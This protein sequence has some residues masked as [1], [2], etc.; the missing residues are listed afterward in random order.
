MTLELVLEVDDYIGSHMVEGLE[1]EGYWVRGVYLKGN[2]FRVSAAGE[3]S[4][5]DLGDTQFISHVHINSESS[6]EISEIHQFAADMVGAGLDFTCECDADFMHNSGILNL[7][8]S[9]ERKGK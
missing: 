1:S 6:E 4:L 8:V 7:N 2:E 5:E 9:N 3:F